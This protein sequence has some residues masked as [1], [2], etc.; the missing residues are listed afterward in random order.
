MT[1]SKEFNEGMIYRDVK[2]VKGVSQGLTP[3]PGHKG[4][5]GS[6]TC[7]KVTAGPLRAGEPAGVVALGRQPQQKQQGMETQF[8]LSLPVTSC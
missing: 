2:R 1:S 3:S 8:S 7:N 4:Q 6:C 5:G